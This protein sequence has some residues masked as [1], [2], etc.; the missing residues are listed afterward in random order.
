MP[1]NDPKD[2]KKG[3]GL[4]PEKAAPRQLAGKSWFFGI[5]INEYQ[6]FSNLN[7]AVKDVKDLI[8]LLQEQYGLD[9]DLVVTLFDEAAVRDNIIEEL[10]ALIK[11]IGPEDK[12]L[13]YYSGHGHLDPDTNLAYWIPQDARQQRTSSYIP[14]SIIRDLI[15]TIP[16]LHTL[17]I[18]DSCFSGS[19][20]VRGASRSDEAAD[21]LEQRRS[22]WGI[23]SGRHDEAVYDGDPGTNSPFAA[24]ILKV[25]NRNRQAKLNVARLADQVV[26]MTRA[27]YHQLPEGNPL[28]GVGHDGGQYVFR[29][30]AGEGN[31]W[32]RCLAEHSLPAYNDYLDQFPNGVHADEALHAI[33]E[34]EEENK[35][36]STVRMD[37]IYAYRSFL[38]SFPEGKYA[39]EAR[40][41]IQQLRS[42]EREAE[43]EQHRDAVNIPDT[44]RKEVQREMP[45]KEKVDERHSVPYQKAVPES[46]SP[47]PL[48]KYLLY[49]LGGLL[50]IVLAVWL[51]NW[52]NKGFYN[53]SYQNLTP[54][55]GEN[56]R[57]GYKND[58]GEV[59]IPAQFDYAYAFSEN[60]AVVEM[61]SLH[62]I[63]N[64][65][66]D[67]LTPTKYQ[68][69]E[70]F[71]HG[72]AMVM[73]KGYYGFIDTTGNE[74]I[75]L[76]YE[77]A[78]S[79]DESNEAWVKMDGRE[80]HID[81]TGKCV[82]NCDEVK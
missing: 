20:F 26:E 23:S 21:E 72:M 36:Q 32:E 42:E 38:Q 8:I 25:L 51:P 43:G 4:D 53:P 17:L 68:Q 46:P 40:N 64:R 19:L 45:P 15:K 65:K 57:Y 74:V 54:F 79:F 1:S 7:N 63:I 35:W 47:S 16:S 22:R 60:R 73:L 44:T 78:G 59:I 33:R 41:R 49:A 5:G 62:A 39:A 3:F 76:L 2:G 61:D 80:F 77:N 55:E 34:L 71:S 10:Y 6:H 31:L 81:K 50:L 14:N 48:R 27:N 29:L 30:A 75:T 70:A 56:N 37:Q 13:I 67:L 9:P 28:F 69:I 24:S 58:A 11:K 12:L 18:S 52:N 82:R 66:G